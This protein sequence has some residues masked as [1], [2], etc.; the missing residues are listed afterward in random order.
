MQ[1]VRQW[2]RGRRKCTA[3][4]NPQGPSNGK[5]HDMSGFGRHESHAF[6]DR[7]GVELAQRA[8]DDLEKFSVSGFAVAF[9][10][11]ITLTNRLTVFDGSEGRGALGSDLHLSVKD[12][13][14]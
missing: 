14:E 12:R 3:L 1:T 6:S 4:Y 5:L 13:Q 2:S 9:H 10:F 8:N 11:R 7:H